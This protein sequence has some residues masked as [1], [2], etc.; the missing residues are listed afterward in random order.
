MLTGCSRKPDAAETE[1]KEAAAPTPAPTPEATPTAAPT[2]EAAKAE[3]KAEPGVT[4]VRLATT[5]GDILLAVHSD[6]A[7]LGAAR[8]LELVKAKYYDDA[9]FFR[10]VPNFVV[11]F[12][13]AANP[14]VTK[15]WDNPIKDDPVTKTNRTGTLSF[16][17]AGPNTRTAQ[18]FINL[19]S[20]MMLD[21]QG[22]APFAE[23][24]EGMSVVESLYAG[25]GEMPDQ[26]LITNQGNAYLKTKFPKLDFIKTARIAP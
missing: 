18:I 8:F 15:K 16:A 1:R 10:V 4:K 3:P 7:P 6:W 20:N 11:Q 25:Y 22:F 14:A 17:T 21:G 12:G 5:K 26:G 24:V 19:R 9:G 13:L 23:V 2:P